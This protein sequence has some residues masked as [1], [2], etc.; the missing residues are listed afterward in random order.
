MNLSNF[1][2]I[3]IVSNFLFWFPVITSILWIIS[4]IHFY[5]SKE[6]NIVEIDENALPP[7][8]IVIAAHNEE[9]FI[10]DTLEALKNLNYPKYDVI[11]VDDASK[12]KTPQII[13]EYLNFENFHFIKLK[14]NVGKAKAINIGLIHSKS[15][16]IVVID[17]DTILDK[18]SIKY[19]AH[20]FL[21]IP[22]LAAVTGNPRVLNRTNILTYIQTA[23]FSSIISLLKRAQRSIGRIFTVSGAF[24]MYNKNVLKKVGCF[25][26]LTATEDI[27]ITWR[28]EKN[29]YN[30]FYEPRAIAWIRVPENLKELIRQRKRWALGG[31]HML[32]K[33]FDILFNFKYK[34]LIFTFIEFLLA[35]IWSIL[36]VILTFLWFL[37][38][39][40]LYRGFSIS[41]IPTWYG[42]FISLVCLIQ[43]LVSATLDKNYDREIFKYY[44]YVVWY[45]IIY[46][47]LNPILVFITLKEGLF[48]KLEGKGVWRPPDRN[49]VYE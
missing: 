19:M 22:R 26:H 17:A 33:H 12:D 2:V 32:R 9:K 27:D 8:T 41:P 15:D 7:V 34:R 31:W 48:G 36:F 44:F 14:K 13:E 42:A 20:H 46:W 18:N 5:Y 40:F 45:P 3:N 10:K 23:E 25:S 47:T 43:F 29:F 38:K 11:I 4:A 35:Y 30:I 1:T 49:L 37:S 21:K 24:T 16:L 6:K 28:I 39:L